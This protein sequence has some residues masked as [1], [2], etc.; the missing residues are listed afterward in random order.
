MSKKKK[1]RIGRINPLLLFFAYL[2]MRPLYK[3]KYGL[4][5]DRRQLKSHKGP[6]I[7]IA[8]HTSDM[9]HIISALALYPIR[10]TYIVSEHFMKKKKTARLLKIAKVITKKMFYPDASTIVNTVRAV[11]EGNTIVIFPEGRLSSYGRTL[12]V[13]SGTAELVKKLGIDLFVLTANGAYLTFPKWRDKGTSR[14]GRIHVTVEKLLEREEISSLSVSRIRSIISDAVYHDDEAA[15]MGIPYRSDAMARGAE[16]I[17]YK[18]PVCGGERCISTQKNS[19]LCTCGLFARLNEYYRFTD[20]I[21]AY[22]GTVIASINE[23]FSW[24]EN[25]LDL[26][27]PLA[28]RIRIGTPGESGF[29]IEDA[30]FGSAL[31]TRDELVIS[32]TL[33]G[34]PLSLAV[35]TERI[36]AFPVTPGE[37]FDIY[38]KGRLL[39]LYPSEPLLT[40]KWVSFLDR[41]SKE[42]ENENTDIHP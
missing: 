34:E 8:P 3:I 37:H 42:R 28:D 20:P 21:A 17:L 38:Y 6:A 13:A 36:G 1:K 41:L 16:R 40:V 7:I 15:M 30:G 14:R 5:V 11:H 10:P 32:G 4:T 33:S 27:E 2:F 31:L 25:T 22:D 29:M 18:C 19:I 39:Y 26:N 23:W 12:P 24:Q 9:D 35:S